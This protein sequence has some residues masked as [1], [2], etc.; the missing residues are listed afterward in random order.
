MLAA[1]VLPQAVALPITDSYVDQRCSTRSSTPHRLH[2]RAEAA[3]LTIAHGAAPA[4]PL[5]AGMLLREL[6]PRDGRGL[7]RTS[8]AIAAL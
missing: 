4:G 3:R 2:G 8:D 5:F 7:R 1:A 6:E